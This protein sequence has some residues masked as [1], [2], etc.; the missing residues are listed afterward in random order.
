VDFKTQMLIITPEEQS[1]AIEAGERK[2][3]ATA[4]KR[5]TIFHEGIL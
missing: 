4:Q 5:E 3:W 2:Q 1:C